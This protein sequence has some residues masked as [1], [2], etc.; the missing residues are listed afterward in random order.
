MFNIFFYANI[1]L[2]KNQAETLKCSIH[3]RFPE[4][5]RLQL[6]M[7]VIVHSYYSCVCL[8]TSCGNVVMSSYLFGPVSVLM[9][10]GLPFYYLYLY[11]FTNKAPCSMGIS[12]IYAATMY[13]VILS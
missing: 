2:L 3:N 10:H 4:Y 8:A 9:K 13:V 7:L 6:D 11:L 12:H 5:L 1:I